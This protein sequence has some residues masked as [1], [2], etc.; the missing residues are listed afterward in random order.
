MA[1]VG[2]FLITGVSQFYM[3]EFSKQMEDA[4][5][6]NDNMSR[7][8]HDASDGA[9]AAYV[10]ADVVRSYSAALGIDNRQRFFFIL[11]GRD[12]KVLESSNADMAGR[13]DATPNVLTALS[14]DEAGFA[15]SPADSIFDCAVPVVSASGTRYI[16]YIVDTRESLQTL[17]ASLVTIVVEAVLFGLAISIMLALLLSKTMTTP[18]ENLT[19]SAARV[20]GGDFS[21]IPDTQSS[22]EI[23]VLTHTFSHMARVLR[24]TL[25]A[26]GS[27]RDKLGTLFLH[28]TDGMMAFT[29]T[30][31]LLHINPAAIRLLGIDG[32]MR[33]DFNSLLGDAARL[34][35]FSELVPPDYVE[36]AFERGG[37]HFRIFFAPF[38]ADSGGG[39]PAEG[40]IMAVVHDITEQMRLDAVRREF[41]SNVSHELRTPLTNVKSYAETIMDNEGLPDTTVRDF[42]G[43]I[44]GEANRM[45]RIVQDL[46]TLSK[47]DYGRMDWRI[48]RV[49]FSVLLPSVRQAMLLDA[50]RR[51]LELALE[52][53]SGLCAIYGDR[54]RLEQVMFNILSNA[55]TYSPDGGSVFIN[56]YGDGARIIIHVR[57]TG[58][59]IPKEDI[60]KVFERFYRVDKARS[61]SFGGTGLGLSIAREIVHKHGGAI[62]IDS[63]LGAG[64]TVTVSLPIDGGLREGVEGE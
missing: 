33:A 6:N 1:V 23:G 26:V 15:L 52:L 12:G 53:G 56:A 34:D 40:G 43:V 5:N 47:F 57:D 8:L 64:T 42:A 18:I 10:L 24:E 13:V 45:T 19:R 3:N 46:L 27:E 48:S 4:F 9:N 35:E 61:R 17:T 32:D 16:I 63:E 2:V 39:V 60:P 11:D 29:R 44:V 25:E 36:K 21:S 49:D 38:G 62:R 30:G 7:L 31:A 14:G 20:A 59:G 54:E 37:S 51:G 55:M 28:M 50:Q 58:V 22:D 41:V